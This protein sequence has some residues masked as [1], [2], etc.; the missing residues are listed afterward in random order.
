MTARLWT[1]MRD[2]HPCRDAAP[3]AAWF[4]FSPDRRG[5][6]PQGHLKSFRGK[7]QADAYAGFHTLYEGGRILEAA[8]WAHARRKFHDILAATQSPTA[9]EGIRRIGE[10]YAIEK[11]VRGSPPEIRLAMRQTRARPVMEGLKA[12]FEATIQTLSAKSDMAGAI[13][14]ALSR[15]T[16]LTRYLDGGE[17][18][19]DNNAAERALRVVAGQGKLSLCGIEPERGT[20]RRFLLAHRNSQ[21]QRTQPKD[22]SPPCPRTHRKSPHQPH[23][24]TVAMEYP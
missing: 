16:A 8:C 1:Y 15:G 22:L 5:E 21:A 4:A 24:R 7:L 6:H 13:R 12:W 20:S 14:Y 11:E 19:I 17:V 23:H 3:P 10:L 2:G 9:S 18:E